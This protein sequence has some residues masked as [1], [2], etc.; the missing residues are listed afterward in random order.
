MELK[1]ELEQKVLNEKW[2]Q[3]DRLIGRFMLGYAVVGIGLSAVYDT[4]LLGTAVSLLLLACYYLMKAMAKGTHLHRYFASLAFGI[5]MALYIYQMHG[6][7]EM[8]FFAFIGSV[9]MVAYQRWQFQIPITAF[10]V[11]HHGVFGWLQFTGVSGIYF[12]QLEYMDA[13]T[14]IIHVILA[15][16]IFALCGYWAYKF[17]EYAINDAKR[18]V[19]LERLNSQL[20]S[21]NAVLNKS[22]QQLASANEALKNEH[23]ELT[24]MKEKLMDMNEKQSKINRALLD[25][26]S[27]NQN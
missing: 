25:M 17:K 14:F 16:V 1:N 11:V 18:S 13:Q 15:A 27:E 26:N 21:Q 23:A 8:H 2:E 20:S 5:F 10:V 4:W 19:E 6:L 12:T 24:E 9:I 7:F 22:K 3:A